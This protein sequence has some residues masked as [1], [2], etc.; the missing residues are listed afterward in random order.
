MDSHTVTPYSPPRECAEAGS[1]AH[2]QDG[3]GSTLSRHSAQRSLRTRSSQK[4]TTTPTITRNTKRPAVLFTVRHIVQ[5]RHHGLPHG[6][7]Q[8]LSR[9]F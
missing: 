5:L 2:A 7:P 6:L 8:T 1:E 4:T 9:E 3:T